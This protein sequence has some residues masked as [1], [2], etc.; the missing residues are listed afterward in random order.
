MDGPPYPGSSVVRW[1][2]IGLFPPG[3]PPP[4]GLGGRGPC[5]GPPGKGT[6]RGRGSGS[7]WI[8]VRTVARVEERFVALTAS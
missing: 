1:I 6:G 4:G 2:L 8:T 7:G 5:P 3:R